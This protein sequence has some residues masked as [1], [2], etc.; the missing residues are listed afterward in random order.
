MDGDF[1][2]TDRWPRI[3]RFKEHDIELPVG[4][5]DV[6]PAER[7]AAARAARAGAGARQGRA[8][9]A[10][11]AGRPASGAMLAGPGG[12]DHRIGNGIRRSSCSPPSAPA[13]CCST[14]Y[15][16]SWTRACS[17]TTAST[18]GAPTASAPASAHARAAQG[19]DDTIADDNK[20]ASRSVAEPE[21][22]DVAT[23]PARPAT[24]RGSNPQARAVKFD[25]TGI[26]EIAALSVVDVRRWIESLQ[27]EGARARR[28]SR[29]TCSPRSGA[30]SNSWRK[31]ACATSRWTAARRRSPAAKRSA[32]GWRRS[33][34]PTCRA[35]ATCSTSR[36]S[37]CIARDNQ[38]LLDALHKLGDKGNTLVVVEHDEDTIRRA[39]HIIDIGPGAGKRGGRVV[40]QGTADDMTAS[41]DSLTGRYLLQR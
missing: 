7:G 35:S 34:A 36:P 23:R 29:A 20:G 1:L 27:L 30:G 38:I 33:S 39:D 9:R 28:A 40:A 10:G 37:A 2:P 24:A 41:P 5:L 32:S 26:A 31:S 4:D 8:A 25:G 15:S 11:A 3:D 14:S 13:P 16:R 22:E 6:T 18:A 19:F 12:A 21:V 17:R